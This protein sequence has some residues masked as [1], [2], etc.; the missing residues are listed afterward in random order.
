MTSKINI[1]THML[2]QKLAILG[3][4]LFILGSQYVLN[5][6]FLS[7]TSISIMWFFTSVGVATM[8]VDFWFLKN[9]R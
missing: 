9:I 6:E 2:W 5:T 7:K 8:I 3:G 1:N 4:L